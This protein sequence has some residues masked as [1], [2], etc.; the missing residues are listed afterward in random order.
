MPIS[1]SLVSQFAGAQ[2]AAQ[3][4]VSGA[5]LEQSLGAQREQGREA[6]D[7]IQSAAAT[8]RGGLSVYA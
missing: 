2:A 8:A 7:L 5:V 1:M 6:L 3:Q 4:S